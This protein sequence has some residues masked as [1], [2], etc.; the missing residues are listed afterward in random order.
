MTSQAA[1]FRTGRPR[2]GDA[3]FRAALAACAAVV[4]VVPGLMLADTTATAWP[5]LRDFGGELVAGTRWAPSAGA[6]GG[7]PFVYGTLVT[8]AI[9]IVLAVPV[10]IGIALFLNEVAPPRLRTPLVYLVELLAAVPSVVYGLW[11]VLVLAPFLERDVW[12]PLSEAFGFVPLLG[13]PAY[14]RSLATAGVVLAIMIL[15]VVTAIAREVTALVP[16]DQ[17]AAALALGVTRWEALRHA[18]LPYAKGGIVGAL[19]LGFGRAL[20]ETIAV[21]LVVG[22]SPQLQPSLLQ[23]GSTIASVIASQFNEAT[24]LQIRALVA[25]AVL[26][27]AITILVNVAGR[28]FVWRSERRLR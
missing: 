21:A 1:A 4:L 6:Y 19:M 13:G 20:G 8:A 18:V 27:F 17:K 11:G 24:G 14:G 10:A 12:G 2:R 15:P 22:G 3:I 26:L 25:L 9:A 5:V 23:P 28:I 7:L 16:P